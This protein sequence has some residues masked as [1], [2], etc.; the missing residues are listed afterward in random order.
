MLNPVH[1]R[2]LGVVLAAGSFADAARRLGYTPSAVS[3]QISTLERLLRLTLFERDAHAIRPTAAAHAVAERAIPALGA[4]RTL[5]EDLRMLAGGTI[6]RL[7]IVSFPTASEQLLPAALSALRRQRPRV[8]VELD[9]AEPQRSMQ[10]LESG[11]VDVVLVYTY[12]TV[13]PRWARAHALVPIL[14]EDLLLISRPE[15]PNCSAESD[16]PLDDL[17]DFTDATWIA[18]REDTLG[19]ANVERLCRESGFEPHIRYRSNNYG[20]IEGLVASGLGVALVPALGL[21]GGGVSA[22][23]VEDTEAKRRVWAVTAST[24]PAELSEVFVTALRR[25]ASRQSARFVRVCNTVD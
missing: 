13:A 7:R 17:G 9:E 5:D 14:E 11:E 3:Q 10:L 8:E 20:V 24:I 19:A 6:G 1:L 21:E 12:G 18:T 4:L 22:Q 16:P 23:R 2:T 25:A 15:R